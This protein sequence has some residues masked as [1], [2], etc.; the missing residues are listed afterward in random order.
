MTGLHQILGTAFVA[1]EAP[2]AAN[3]VDPR[4]EGFSEGLGFDILGFAEALDEKESIF[5]GPAAPDQLRQ[6]HAIIA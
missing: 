3:F 1:G 5:W 4:V 2:H 6:N